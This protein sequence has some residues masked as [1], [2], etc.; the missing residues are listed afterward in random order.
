MYLMAIHI[1]I[2]LVTKVSRKLHIDIPEIVLVNFPRF[3]IPLGIMLL[4][5]GQRNWSLYVP[6]LQEAIMSLSILFLFRIC[7]MQTCC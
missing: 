5:I 3:G 1:V 4:A 2:R 6:L 7:V